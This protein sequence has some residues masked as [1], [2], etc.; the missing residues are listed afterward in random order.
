[1]LYYYCQNINLELNSLGCYHVVSHERIFI[2]VCSNVFTS[3][4]N[5]MH[6]AQKTVSL[7]CHNLVL[8]VSMSFLHVMDATTLPTKIWI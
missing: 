6:A 8:Y 5:S 3:M 1:M 4:V 7:N 2:G